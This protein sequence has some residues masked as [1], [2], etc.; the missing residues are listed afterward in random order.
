MQAEQFSLLVP[1]VLGHKENVVHVSLVGEH[2]VVPYVK[3]DRNLVGA[4]PRTPV[5]RNVYIPTSGALEH[6][7]TRAHFSIEELE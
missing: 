3:N 2:M 6:D 4:A 1:R 5:F 7:Q